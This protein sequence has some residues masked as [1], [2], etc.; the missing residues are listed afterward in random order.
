MNT[1]K[2][3]IFTVLIG[4]ILLGV[5]CAS[6]EIIYNPDGGYNELVTGTVYESNGTTPCEGVQVTSRYGYT[7]TDAFGRF[8]L[9]S[10]YYPLE[11]THKLVFS[12]PGHTS[13]TINSTD[14]VYTVNLND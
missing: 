4:A 7:Y 1:K 2:T 8:E 3:H 13:F 10:Y 9:L 5:F 14:T 11:R 6:C 12:K